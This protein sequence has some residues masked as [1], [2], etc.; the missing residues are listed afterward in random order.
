MSN[1]QKKEMVDL[2]TKMIAILHT[3]EI[4]DTTADP[5]VGPHPTHPPKA[6]NEEGI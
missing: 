4:T 6:V 3:I 1:E 5:F 2:L